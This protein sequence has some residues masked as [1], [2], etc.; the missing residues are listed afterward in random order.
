[1]INTKGAAST[2]SININ[3]LKIKNVVTSVAVTSLDCSDYDA[4]NMPSK[5]ERVSPKQST[6]TT[7]KSSKST[8][9]FDVT[10]PAKTFQVFKIKI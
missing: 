9:T 5:P 7:L 3:G 10:V 8:V 2:T 6:L 4:E 1:M